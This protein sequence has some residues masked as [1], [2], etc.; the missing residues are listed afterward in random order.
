MDLGRAV[1]WA[2]QLM[3]SHWAEG[4]LMLPTSHRDNPGLWH[5]KLDF[6]HLMDSQICHE[7]K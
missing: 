2:V 5:F 6:V 1:L 3:R 7:L 4:E